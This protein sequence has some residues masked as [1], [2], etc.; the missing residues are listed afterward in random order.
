MKIV[1]STGYQSFSVSKAVY[2]ELGLDWDN[3]GY[4]S[5]YMPKAGSPDS[6]RCDKKLI[7][8]IE[9]LGIKEASGDRVT[10][11]IVEIPDGIQWYI[12]EDEGCESI[13]ECHRSWD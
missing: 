8:A 2:E 12:H 11:K 13:H 6:I 9:K 10:L 5:L 7:A 3:Y 4:L 1:I